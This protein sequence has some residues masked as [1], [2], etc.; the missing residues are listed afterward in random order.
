MRERR[1]ENEGNQ[2]QNGGADALA[3]ETDALDP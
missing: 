2:Q 1:K 3:R